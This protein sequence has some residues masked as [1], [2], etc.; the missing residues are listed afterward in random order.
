MDLECI[1][2]T[3]PNKPFV[4]LRPRNWRIEFLLN[5]KNMFSILR[6]SAL[7]KFLKFPFWVLRMRQFLAGQLVQD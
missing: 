6:C 2:M 3:Q 5:N 1:F 4:E 7:L